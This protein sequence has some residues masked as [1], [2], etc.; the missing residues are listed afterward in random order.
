MSKESVQD[1]ILS[2]CQSVPDFPKPG[3]TFRDLTPVFADSA[4]FSATVHALIEPFAGTFDRVA[5]VE[6][7]GFILAAA[8]AFASGTGVTA[9]RKP[10]KLPREV[11]RE[12]YA[13]E[14]GSAAVEIHQDEFV[15]G[16]RVL[17]LDDVL[18]TGGTL[19][20]AVRLLER[21]GAEV[22]GIAVVLELAGLGGAAVVPT[23]VHSLVTI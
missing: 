9:V 4:A 18:A 21:A 19:S 12:E 8:T 20:A 16:T 5:G 23:P 3:V 10:G 6:A 13:L 7:R 14:Y 15:P 22:V 1:L 17:L 2:R 11:L